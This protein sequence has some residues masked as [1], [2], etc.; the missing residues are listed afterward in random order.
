LG[1]IGPHRYVVANPPFSDK[2][3]SNGIDP[4]NDPHDRFNRFGTP[5][6]RQGDYAYLLYIIRSLKSAKGAARTAKR[7]RNKIAPHSVLRVFLKNAG[8]GACILPHGVLFRGNAEAEIRRNLIRKR[9]IQGIV[10]LPPNLFYGAGIPACIVLID[11]AEAHTRKGIFMIDAS[12]GY[13]KDGN[14]NRLRAMDIHKIVD[15]FNKRLE[16]PQYSRMVSVAE[17]EK[18]D[19]NLNLPRYIDS[20]QPE[21]VQDIAGH[22]SGGIPIAD[23]DEPSSPPST[24]TRSSPPSSAP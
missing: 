19:F 12:A 13:R 8:K 1:S 23:I 3:W 22:L 20:R 10:G 14:K 7:I 18:N 9:Y 2:R 21:D 15:V 6:A 4:L 16:I 17:I 24:S 11:K 5:P